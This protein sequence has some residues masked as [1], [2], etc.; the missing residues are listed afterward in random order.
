MVPTGSRLLVV[1]EPA[2]SGSMLLR[3][4]AGL[5]RRSGGEVEI[6]GLSDPSSDG[7]ARRTAYLGAQPGIYEW[8]TPREALTLAARL[9][10]LD[11]ATAARRFE[12]VTGRARI[13]A[14]SL[15][16]AIRR[17]S[18]DIA[19]RTG[20]AAALLGDPEVLLLDEP[21]RAVDG[22]ERSAMLAFPADRRT[23]I[24]HSRS[25]ATEAAHVSH[26]ALLR[27]GR[28]TMLATVPD[29]ESLGEGLTM[30][31][32]VELANRRPAGRAGR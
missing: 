22:R 27:T 15:D 30:R 13:P 12:E 19:Q 6:A 8:M 28:V 14:A 18:A 3:V 23:V 7:W 21:L 20:Y 24:L 4:L 5:A 9:L 29:V 17:G 10:A 16:R 31:A 26:V 32:I 11:R 2:A 25:P 1:A